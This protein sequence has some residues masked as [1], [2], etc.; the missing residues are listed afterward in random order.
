MALD[1][2]VLD[3]DP[4]PTLVG[5]VNAGFA[6]LGLTGPGAPVQAADFLGQ[7]YLDTGTGRIHVARA[8]GSADPAADWEPKLRSGEK[9][10]PLGCAT[11]D[12]QG[13]V[14]AA[15]LPVASGGALNH[16]LAAGSP[17]TLLSTAMAQIGVVSLTPA[18]ASSPVL[19]L[20]RA[21]LT[22]DGGTT[23][24]LAT[25]TLR[26]GTRTADPQI[27]LSS[28]T[29]SQPLASTQFGPLVLLAVDRPATTE[30]VTYGLFGRVDAGKSTLDRFELLALELAG[31]V[32]PE[33]PAGADGRSLRSGAGAPGP[34]LG[35]NGD[36]YV[37][38][39][40]GTLY[41]PK[42]GGS[43]G[44]ATSLIGPAGA[45][46]A[47]GPTGPAGPSG[48]MGAIGPAGPQGPAGPAGPQGAAGP[49]GPS[50]GSGSHAGQ[51]QVTASA[52]VTV[53][54]RAG[55]VRVTGADVA[56]SLD[57]T[58]FAALD[59]LEIRNENGNAAEAG[60]VTVDA[61]SDGIN[62]ADQPAILLAPGD[63]VR[64][65]RVATTAPVWLTLSPIGFLPLE[66]N[67]YAV[68]DGAG[69]AQEPRT[70]RHAFTAAIVD[71]AGDGVHGGFR[72]VWPARLEAVHARTRGGTVGLVVERDGVR[73]PAFA[74][75]Q[76]VSTGEASYVIDTALE[77]GDFIAFRLQT[78]A[79]LTADGDGRKGAYL[80]A[81]L[82][83]TGD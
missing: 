17:G 79:G 81:V 5:K 82:V 25:L 28:L 46:G 29:R 2:I 32:G 58:G 24:R 74:V 83:R 22:K 54:D 80:T 20:A 10:A 37:D 55:L 49:P 64:L 65:V 69:S 21:D 7:E 31:V 30:A 35:E 45:R 48:A 40:A 38:V 9:G 3:A 68:V 70:D 71:P 18:H 77:T 56:L 13:R 52:A 50:G 14:P 66:A 26:R 39:G 62:A 73:L 51:R 59:W 78:I 27:G 4:L 67:Q 16:A 75:A 15:Q 60:I 1:P 19:L 63:T 11:L 44:I 34:E 43:W 8:V 23:A 72:L 6:R 33:G 61:G 41:G 42:S 76:P 53:A 47:T 57:A 36:L 12:A